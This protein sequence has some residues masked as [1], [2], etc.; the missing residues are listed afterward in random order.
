MK[1]T[2]K[3]TVLFEE[4]FWV[5]IF[6]RTYDGRYEVSRIIFG[7]EPKDYEV[8]DVILK[9]FNHIRFTNAIHAKNKKDKKINPK[10]LQRKIREETKDKGI[11]T[12]AQLA[13]KLQHEENKVARKKKSKEKK[14]EEQRRKFELRQQKKKEKHK[15]H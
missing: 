2:S 13:I 1:I 4:P 15:G 7:P 14:E 12:K 10:R 6:E 3:L 8:Y 9:K 11:G 5:G